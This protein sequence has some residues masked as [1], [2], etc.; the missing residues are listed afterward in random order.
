[1]ITQIDGLVV[2]ESFHIIDLLVRE[3]V[4]VH[5]L[6]QPLLI[7]ENVLGSNIARLAAEVLKLKGTGDNFVQQ[8]P[9]LLLVEGRLQFHPVGDLL[10]QRKGV[11]L[12]QDLPEYTRTLRTPALPHLPCSTTSKDSGKNSDSTWATDLMRFRHS[13]MTLV[14]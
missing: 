1:M 5:D 7:D 11:V 2:L 3:A 9:K 13:G 8:E 12:K 6:D 14:S 4:L 10:L